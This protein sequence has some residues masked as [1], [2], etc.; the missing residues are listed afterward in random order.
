M[1]LVKLALRNLA[2][3]KRRTAITFV[4]LVAGVG[5]MVAI[6]GF[7]NGQRRQ[8]LENQ[9]RGNLGALQVHRKGYVANVLASP[10]TLDFADS[11]A[12]RAT[13]AA[14]PAVVA[15]S[16]RIEFGA[17][18]STPDRRPPPDDGSDLPEADRGQSSF[19]L[20]TAI[21]PATERVVTPKRWEWVSW[22]RGQMPRAASDAQVVLND[23]FAKGIAVPLWAAGEAVPPIEQ[24]LA[25][26][27]PDRDGSLNGVNVVMAGT[28]ASATPND[29]RVGLMPL[30]TAQA[31][32]RME[33]R[34]TEYG[35]AVAEGADLAE[36]KRLVEA[37]VGA[38]FEVHTW[39]ERLPFVRD[40]VDTQDFVF[41]IVSGIFLF[42]VLLGVV[43]AMLMSV[44]ERV[45]EI[46]TMLAVGMRRRQ[47]VQL[48][49]AEGVVLGLVGGAL[50]ALVGFAWVSWMNARGLS[51]P[52]PGAKVP[53][54]LRPSV[55]AAFL[56]RATLQATAG[57]ALA[58]L[59]PAWRASRL[60]PVEALAHT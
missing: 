47:V 41:G 46:G 56:A 49:I 35:L 16:P 25:V 23:D 2:R 8:I 22:A 54:L 58:S 6:K 42:V 26:L 10:L 28:L 27:A 37:A 19:L 57:A 44:L 5:A 15:V 12:L 20:F 13:L 38:D 11:P 43:N 34:V 59:W 14:V 30:A 45:R 52:A 60:R 53:S 24:Q 7:M 1:A 29:R 9:Q 33:G 17:Q 31:L 36:V 55:D 40:I 51:I 4:A 50:G 39:E 3:N 48:F 32:L 21:D 18:L